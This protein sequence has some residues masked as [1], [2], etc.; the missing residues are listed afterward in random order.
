MLSSSKAF[1]R[2]LKVVMV[3]QDRERETRDGFIIWAD[4][5]SIQKSN[6]SR[7]FYSE[8]IGKYSVNYTL[9]TMVK[10]DWEIYLKN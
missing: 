3:H 7:I 10:S 9:F 8:K 1:S 6:L 2:Y 5:A 4:N